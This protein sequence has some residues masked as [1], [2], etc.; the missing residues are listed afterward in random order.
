MVILDGKQVALTL[1]ETLKK[2]IEKEGK[3]HTLTIIVGDDK[4]S[5]TYV[6]M[7]HKACEECGIENYIEK[8]DND[9][10]T[11]E[12]VHFCESVNQIENIDGYFIQLPLPKHIDTEKVLST[13]SIEKDIDCLNPISLGK[14]ASGSKDCFVPATVSGIYELLKWYNIETEGK[15]VVVIGRSN[16]VGLPTALVMGL[17][18]RGN[19]NVTLLHSATKYEDLVKYTRNADIIISSI[20]KPNFITED[21]VSDGVVI[22][23]VS[24]VPIPDQSK[25]SGY[26]MV[27]DVDFDKVSKKCSY[28]TPVPGGCG[29]MTIAML[30]YNAKIAYD[31][32]KALNLIK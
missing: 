32:R 19:A 27:G 30:L 18:N 10:T 4:A 16:I 23:D 25:K 26:R 12:L 22:V 24:T 7:K 21:M 17:K 11:K 13:I 31:K 29:P 8:F 15:N 28:I 2:Q 20:G 5:E 9:V 1:R 14:L 3:P 6:N